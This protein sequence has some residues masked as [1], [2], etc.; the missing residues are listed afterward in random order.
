MRRTADG[1]LVAL[2]DATLDRTTDETGP[3]REWTYS[4][5]SGV[6][7]GDGTSIPTIPDV[8]DLLAPTDVALQIELKEPGV[9]DM[10]LEL[11]AA[12]ELQDRVVLTS[13]DPDTLPTVADA[14]TE[15]AYLTKSIGQ[16]AL[17]RARSIGVE[18]VCTGVRHATGPTVRAA[19]EEGLQIG[20]WGVNAPAEIRAVLATSADVLSTD[21]PDRVARILEE[22]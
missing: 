20:F 5:L 9:A 10:L 2:H 19:H 12:H 17:H 14:P 7:A 16:D 21:R 1:V 15:R 18:Y 3:L 13:F 8:L 22:T 6:D 4:E 11:L